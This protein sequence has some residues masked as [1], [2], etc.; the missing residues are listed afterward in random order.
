[1]I[2]TGSKAKLITSAGKTSQPLE[3]FFINQKQN[4]LLPEIKNSFLTIDK[5]NVVCSTI[6]P[7][8]ANGTGFILRFFEV[9]GQNTEVKIKLNFL[10]KIDNATETNLIEDDKQVKLQVS[11]SN[12][13]TL[14]IT[15]FGLKT[16]RVTIVNNELKEPSELNTT[17]ISDREIK[18]KWS[19]T[20][21]NI[22]SHYNI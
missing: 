16:I 9:T 13:I 21:D 20:T 19:A 22:I 12:D 5:D 6:K 14:P 1:M 17:A 10:T 4:G 8:E 7:A 3:A 11:D 18:L 15:G 2:T